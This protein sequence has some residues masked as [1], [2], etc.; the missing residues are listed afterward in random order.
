MI[1]FHSAAITGVD[2]R[3]VITIAEVAWMF[4]RILSSGSAGM[5]LGPRLRR[6]AREAGYSCGSR[7][8][9]C[10][11]FHKPTVSRIPASWLSP[12]FN[13]L[14]QIA[15][16][17]IDRL[18][19]TTS[20]IAEHNEVQAIHL[21]R[22]SHCGGQRPRYLMPTISYCDMFSAASAEVHKARAH[23]PYRGFWLCAQ[24]VHSPVAVLWSAGAPGH[25]NSQT[26][27]CLG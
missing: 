3:R 4:T 7:K 24:I 18:L 9:T 27:P 13:T 21:A 12:E 10:C 23:P 14:G 17:R 11:I 26:L 8:N 5:R 16:H 25:G 2:S 1:C 19:R 15:A 6:T 22:S 20:V